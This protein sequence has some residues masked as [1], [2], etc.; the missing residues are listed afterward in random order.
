[1]KRALFVLVGCGFHGVEPLQEAVLHTL[2]FI[3]G[4]GVQCYRM[5]AAE[6]AVLDVG[7]VALEAA[8]QGLDLLPLGTTAA[9]VAHGAV[10]G[11]AAGALDELQLIVALPGQNILF[12][13]AVHGPDEGHAGEA[14]AVQLGRHSLQLRTVE[15]A[16]DGGLDH[17]V[18]VMPQRDLVAAQLLG[19]AV[20]VAAAH[21]GAE[22]AGVLVSVVGH[23]KDVALENGH[24][25]VQQLGVGLDLLAIDLVVAGVHDQKHQL[26][27]HVAV[28]LQLLHELGHQHGVLAA[29][30][31]HGNA[32]TGLHQLVALDRHDEGGPQFFAIFFDDAAFDQLIG[33]QSLFHGLPRFTVGSECGSRHRKPVKIR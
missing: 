29:G 26:K 18:E 7:V 11:K 19:L 15:H 10:L 20:Q 4:H 2:G 27:G 21:P 5:D 31:A 8:Q 1:M 28:A 23:G 3:A 13:D 30:N 9:V 22:V 32:V 12:M 33:F 25:D 6:D 17:I 24:R 16:H 14:G